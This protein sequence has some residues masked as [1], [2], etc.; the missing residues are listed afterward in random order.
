MG[1]AKVVVQL[2]AV[3]LGQSSSWTQSRLGAG[4][5]EIIA[6]RSGCRL[7]NDSF[8]LYWVCVCVC[9]YIDRISNLGIEYPS[10]YSL[11][12]GYGF[13]PYLSELECKINQIRIIVYY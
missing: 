9:V 10:I 8:V 6:H 4:I 11:L 12:Y 7:E 1:A 5:S 3:P 13:V 2:D